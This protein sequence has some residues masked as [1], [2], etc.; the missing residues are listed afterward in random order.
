MIRLGESTLPS[1]ISG[2]YIDGI[3]KQCSKCKEIK[4]LNEFCKDKTTKDGANGQCKI[5]GKIS[6]RKWQLDNPTKNRKIE[7]NTY[8]R[9]IKHGY[10]VYVYT[11]QPTQ[12]FY[13]GEGWLYHRERNHIKNNK[14][15][16]NNAA[17]FQKHWNLYPNVDEWE[18][19]VIKKWSKN[20]PKGR[21]LE[22]KLINEGRIKH[23]ALI[24]NRKS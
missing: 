13:I 4:L 7:L 8:A 21:E 23:P 24:L 5:C 1:Y 11:H 18:F 6:A 14:K 2:M 15:G 22:K 19:K 3:I 16:D 9:Q 17:G 10:G 12:K 20:T